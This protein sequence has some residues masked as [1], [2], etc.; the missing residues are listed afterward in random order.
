MT[1]VKHCQSN[2]RRGGNAIGAG[3]PI[4]NTVDLDIRRAKPFVTG[5]FCSVRR[6]IGWLGLA[7]VVELSLKRPAA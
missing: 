7:R 3:A 5:Q 4:E 2:E 1:S 6:G